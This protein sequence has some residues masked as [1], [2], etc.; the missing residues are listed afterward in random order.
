MSQI[1]DKCSRCGAPIDWEKGASSTKCGYC[2]K[3]NYLR[4]F[5]SSQG[6]KYS[7]FYSIKSNSQ[8]YLLAI[9]EKLKKDLKNKNIFFEDLIYKYTR[10]RKK[11]AK[12]NEL[13]IL[14][15]ALPI[16][17][18]VL[19]LNSYINSPL[20]VQNKKIKDA[21]NQGRIE[22]IKYGATKFKSESKYK[23]CIDFMRETVLSIDKKRT[24]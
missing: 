18:F 2:G 12:R 23:E 10:S 6:K 14:L 13:K 24:N 9:K 5:N 8:K 15:T 17:L 20:R 22:S 7:F 1:P 3:I 16:G 21:C 4:E 19:M 11:I